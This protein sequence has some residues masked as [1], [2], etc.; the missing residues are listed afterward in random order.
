MTP[1]TSPFGAVRLFTV[2]EAAEA[3]KLPK[4]DL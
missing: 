3:L 1:N 2:E 4:S